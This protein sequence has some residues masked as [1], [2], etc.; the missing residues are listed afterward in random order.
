MVEVTGLLTKHVHQKDENQTHFKSKC[1]QMKLIEKCDIQV[2]IK[3]L[4]S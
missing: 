3:S 2:V 1:T 4:L